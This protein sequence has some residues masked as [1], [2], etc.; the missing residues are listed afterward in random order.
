LIVFI[1]LESINNVF[2]CGN[3]FLKYISIFLGKYTK[4]THTHPTHRSFII[5]RDLKVSLSTPRPTSQYKEFSPVGQRAGNKR[6][7]NKI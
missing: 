4:H 5:A 2:L 1:F 3:G 6:R 7:K